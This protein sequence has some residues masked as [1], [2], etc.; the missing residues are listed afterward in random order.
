MARAGNINAKDQIKDNLFHCPALLN[1]FWTLENM[2]RC[3]SLLGPTKIARAQLTHYTHT[4]IASSAWLRAK[5]RTLRF[6]RFLSLAFS[7]FIFF[8]ANTVNCSTE[9]TVSAHSKRTHA[10]IP[11]TSKCET[12]TKQQQLKKILRVFILLI[13]Y[14]LAKAFYVHRIQLCLRLI[15]PEF[16]CPVYL[17]NVSVGA[18]TSTERCQPFLDVQSMRFFFVFFFFSLARCRRHCD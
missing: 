16:A 18:F 8:S 5:F 13:R 10:Y 4:G 17:I 15:A 7:I 11:A 3:W 9:C 1:T 6:F 2:I 12:K 14:N